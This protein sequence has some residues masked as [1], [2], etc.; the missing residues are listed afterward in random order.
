VTTEHVTVVRT[1]TVPID[2]I[3]P[4]P[5]NPRRGDVARIQRSLL[6]H[7][8]YAPLIVHEQTGHILAGNHRWRVMK[9]KMGWTH[10]DARFVSCT[11]AKALQIL[12]M[13]N[14]SS[15]DGTY[16]DAE[17]LALLEAIG[18]SD[19]PAAG[20]GSDDLDDLLARLE[21]DV[22]TDPSGISEAVGIDA[23]KADPSYANSGVRSIVLTYP[24]DE[25][26]Q[27]VLGLQHIAARYDVQDFSDAVARMIAELDD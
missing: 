26:E 4:H 18:D 20:Y 16:N 17:L 15:D 1:D 21:E 7:G 3:T 10:V 5:S 25:Y 19:L 6:E 12:A 22:P 11:E 24:V 8:Q 23:R 14:R 13:D 27:V 2:S 9:E